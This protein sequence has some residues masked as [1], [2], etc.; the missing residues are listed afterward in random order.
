MSSHSELSKSKIILLAVNLATD[1]EFSL[2]ETLTASYPQTLKLVLVLRIILSFVPESTDPL[3]YIPLLKRLL[4]GAPSTTEVYQGDVSTVTDLQETEARR[5]VKGL[6]L[7]SLTTSPGPTLQETDAFTIFLIKRSHLIDAQTGLLNLIPQLILP[8]IDHSESLRVWY[9]STLLP[10]LRLNY[11]YYPRKGSV[12]SSGDFEA[13]DGENGVEQLLSRSIRQF[14]EDAEEKEVGRDLRGV[15]GPW[16]CGV[17]TAKRRR[18]GSA[19]RR[20]LDYPR[21][22]SFS[23]DK[24]ELTERSFRRT[25]SWQHVFDWLVSK[26]QSNFPLCVE[27]I[28]QWGGPSDVDLGGYDNDNDYLDREVQKDLEARYARTAIAIAYLAPNGSIETLTGAH[29][30]LTKVAALMDFE[31]PRDPSASISSLQGF[32][33]TLGTGIDSDSSSLLSHALLQPNNSLTIPTE[34]SLSFL[35]AVIVSSFILARLGQEATIKKVVELRFNSDA[36][37]QGKELQRIIRNVPNASKGD[38]TYWRQLRAEVRWLWRWN[39]ETV[40]NGDVSPRSEGLFGRVEERFVEKELLRAF[41]MHS[42]CDLAISIYLSPALENSPLSPEDVEKVVFDSAMHFYDNATNCNRTRGGMKKA[43]DIIKSF[44]PTHFPKSISLRRSEKLLD[45]T[46]ALSFYSLTMHRG[47]PFQPVNIRIHQD[48]ISLMGKVMEQNTKGYTHLDDLLG[49]G[50]HFVEAGLMNPKID[51]SVIELSSEEQ[52]L[53]L[54]N[55][56]RRV[57]GMAI[58]AALAEGDFET[59]YSYALSRFAAAPVFSSLS[60]TSI[61]DAVIQPKLTKPLAEDDISWR[62]AFQ[63]GRYKSMNP[64]NSS[65]TSANHGIRRLEMRMELLAQ[66]LTLAPPAALPE[67]LGIW[68]RCEEEWNLLM[69]Q[70]IKEED[71]WDEKGDQRIPG[72]FLNSSSP[73]TVR[74]QGGG[75]ATGEDAP[76]G[77]FDV[78]RGAAAA[79]SKSAFPLRGSSGVGQDNGPGPPSRDNTFSSA[80]HE[81]DDSESLD[82]DDAGRTRKRDMVSSMVTGGLASGIGWV[83]DHDEVIVQALDMI[84]RFISV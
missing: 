23:P 56:E 3:Q 50:R 53:L 32:G 28:E 4:A 31:P 73:T 68:R 81:H 29:R 20:E 84:A 7:L 80:R 60:D 47:V 49:I 76:M 2:L 21:T 63:A 9:I 72:Q 1:C 78:A 67:I 41:L 11:E 58:E 18:L 40:S 24:G 57:I 17:N 52:T 59:A 83:L 14:E 39:A 10:L 61:K 5:R 19:E 62:A 30:I 48:P 74:R 45:A 6:H 15:V 26:A 44:Y 55:A 42:R 12:L 43:S 66:A 33:V 54:L 65:E 69:S 77:L 51:G 37:Q 71:R 35:N 27:A 82:V 75:V 36:I 70:E 16:M 64:T 79:L 38:E 22:E 34:E 13:L 8:F 46:H 25:R